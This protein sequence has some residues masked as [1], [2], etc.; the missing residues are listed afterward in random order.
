MHGLTISEAIVSEELGS[1]KGMMI[2]CKDGEC[3]PTGTDVE[4]R[5]TYEVVFEFFKNRTAYLNGDAALTVRDENKRVTVAVEAGTDM[6][7]D[8]NIH[9][10]LKTPLAD[11]YT[12]AD[13]NL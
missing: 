5:D 2:R 11:V 1:K 4:G 10:S 9:L 13:E 3:T 7:D 6:T 8:T 12:L